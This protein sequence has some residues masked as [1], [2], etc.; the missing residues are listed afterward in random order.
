M[1]NYEHFINENTDYL[2]LVE[3]SILKP[4]LKTEKLQELV[5]SAIDKNIKIISAR[6]EYI[7]DVKFMIDKNPI[8]I[9][10]V[11]DFPEGTQKHKANIKEIN[12]AIISGADEIELTLNSTIFTKDLSEKVVQKLKVLE[13]NIKELSYLC[14]KNGVIFKVILNINDLTLD[15][16]KTAADVLT[17][18]NIDYIQTSTGLKTDYKKANYLKK[19]IPNSLKIKIAGDIR[20]IDNMKQYINIADRFGTSSLIF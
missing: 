4:D 18:S 12:K 7:S 13:E 17:N 9:S 6:V 19:I 10:A 16:L 15:Q 8:K 11:I 14:H 1:K 5:T 2:S 20:T 3:F